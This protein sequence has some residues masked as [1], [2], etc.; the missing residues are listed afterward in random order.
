MKRKEERKN[1]KKRVRESDP[2]LTQEQEILKTDKDRWW[3]R[4]EGH[5]MFMRNYRGE[6]SDLIKTLV[7]FHL[8]INA[9]NTER[10]RE[11][12][13]KIYF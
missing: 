8:Q 6:K 9:P 7:L 13:E 4:M 1:S 3:L 12:G 5:I 11:K 2:I 10:K